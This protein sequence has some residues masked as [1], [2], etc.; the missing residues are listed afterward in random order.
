VA[1]TGQTAGNSGRDVLT[2]GAGN[3]TLDGGEGPDT[4]TGGTGDDTYYLDSGGD[5]VIE[6]PGAGNDTVFATLSYA[7]ADNV[8]NLFLIGRGGLSGEGNDLDNQITGN[9]GPNRLTG[10]LGAD[11]LTGGD[12][13]DRFI[14]DS[15]AESPAGVG[16]Y[17]VITDFDVAG[18]DRI[19]L[20][21]IDIDPV[22]EGV[23]G[24]HYIG[25][26]AFSADATGELRFD[27]ATHMLYGSTNADAAA[28]FAVLL[29]GVTDLPAQ[30]LQV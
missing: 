9:D 4:M 29:V 14:I 30:A 18:R 11:T 13:A 5:K 19:D 27:A 15:V 24:F 8:E 6:A 12:G 25:T 3:D 21:T 17:D 20:H 26:A 2:G 10:G 1:P 23:Q 28:E 7:L 22:K 16:T